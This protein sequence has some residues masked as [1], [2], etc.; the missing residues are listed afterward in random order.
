MLKLHPGQYIGRDSDDDDN[1]ENPIVVIWN[2]D[3]WI[4]E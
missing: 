4:Y 2:R 1:D 3:N